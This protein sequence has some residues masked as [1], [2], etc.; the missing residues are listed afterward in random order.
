MP[1]EDIL[2]KIGKEA[3]IRK[4]AILAKASEEAKAKLRRIEEEINKEAAHLLER[5]KK[6]AEAEA[7]QKIAQAKLES[8]HEI[9]R[10]KSEAIKY[11]RQV[12]TKL[13][14]EEL[15]KSYWSW[16]EEILLQAVDI[17]DEEV[18]MF[19]QEAERLGKDFLEK[20][21]QKTHYTL[22]WG[23]VLENKNERGFVLKKGG[24]N[25]NL[26]FSSLLDEFLKKNESLIVKSLFQGVDQ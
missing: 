6:E 1:L 11:L 5:R 10:M 18:W 20:I 23:G 7:Q 13:F 22:R 21:N 24:M 12:L 4:Q 9:G 26:T 3:E 17:G 8:R 2:E 14:F 19:P 25:L 15:D 16:C